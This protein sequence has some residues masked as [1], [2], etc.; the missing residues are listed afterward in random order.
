MATQTDGGTL[1]GLQLPQFYMVLGGVT[2]S[3]LL[4]QEQ[5]IDHLCRFYASVQHAIMVV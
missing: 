4:L 3:F 1:L 2:E 5:K